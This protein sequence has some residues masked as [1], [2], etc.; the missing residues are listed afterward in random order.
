MGSGVSYQP[1]SEL[2]HDKYEVSDDIVI[3]LK[4]LTKKLRAF[5]HCTSGEILILIDAHT[6]DLDFIKEKGD[7]MEAAIN[8]NL[9]QQHLESLKV[10][11]GLPEANVE[12]ERG[13]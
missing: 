3:P 13:R 6:N 5:Q 10:K 4:D 12:S 1:G 8:H 9:Q 11:L 2:A 7:W